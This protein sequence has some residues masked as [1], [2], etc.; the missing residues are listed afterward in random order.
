MNVCETT[1]NVNQEARPK[2]SGDEDQFFDYFFGSHHRPPMMPA[3]KGWHPAADLF[4]TSTHIVVVIDIAGIDV[5]DVNLELEKGILKLSGV[6][7]EAL[8]EQKRQYHK[9]E[10]PYGPFERA[11]RLP[12]AVR[13]NKVTAD[14]RGGLLT[15]RL[16][17][18][19]K[20]LKVQR[21][22]I[23]HIQ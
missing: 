1:R 5:N 17:K 6:R 2:S 14:Y 9:M 15:V 19:E 13:G 22:I 3:E 12:C 16:E 4:E 21:K 8:E 11:L 18:Q 20:P 10:V 23:L 7:R